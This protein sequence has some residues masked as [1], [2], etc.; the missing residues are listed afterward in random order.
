MKKVKIGYLDCF[1][2]ISGDMTLGAFVDL[3]VPVDWLRETLAEMPLEGFGLEAKPVFRNGIRA[4]NIFVTAAETHASRN[5]AR[6]RALITGSPF[7]EKVKSLSLGMFEKVAVAEAHIHGCTL[8]KVHFHEVGGIDAI[9]DIVGTALCVERLGIERFAARTVPLGRGVVQ[10]AHGTLPL[11]APA[12]LAI[13]KGVP[14]HGTD[15]EGELV[16][17][18]GAAIIKTLS[19]SF[20]GMPPMTVQAVGY[21]AGKREGTERPNLLRVVVGES[22]GTS[23]FVSEHLQT[24]TVMVVETSIDDM[25]PEFY[26]FLM[27]RLFDE[28]AL[29]VVWS[30]VFMKKNRPGTMVQVLCRPDRKEKITR[31]ILSETTAIGVRYGE[32]QRSLLPRKSVMVSTSFGEIKAK[33]ITGVNGALRTVPEF[34]ACKAVA[35]EKGM[36]MR[37]VYDAILREIGKS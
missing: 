33:Q 7:S 5:Y 4:Q 30:P 12:T 1:S 9:V 37:V 20:D 11:P 8:E 3:G 31:C 29:D 36:P 17:P 16:T 18:T 6:I 34:E 21:G 2:G 13:L 24:D 14:V 32:M 10:C 25:N 26:G 15:I 28:G 23:G 22:V 19:E 35:L 27:E